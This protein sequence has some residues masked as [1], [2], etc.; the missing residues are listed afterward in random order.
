MKTQFFFILSLLAIVSVSFAESTHFP[1]STPTNN[2]IHFL[3]KLT[4]NNHDPVNG[5]D[6]VA[7]FVNDGNGGEIL[8]GK[9]I[10]GSTTNNYYFVSVYGDDTQ[11]QQKDGALPGDTLIFKVWSSQ[12]NTE[13]TILENQLS[14]ESA[15]GITLPELP[16]KYQSTHL[17]QYGYLNLQ[18]NT[19]VSETHSTHSIPTMTEWGIICF[20]SMLIVIS[21]MTIRKHILVQK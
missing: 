18:F 8:I 5:V 4:M 10:V 17:A 1:D 9:A 3:G 7:V 6:E 13:Q 11:T 12:Y 16:P 2:W 21:I 15:P 20:M 14:I 19:N